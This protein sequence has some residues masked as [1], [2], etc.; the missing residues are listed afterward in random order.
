ME[1]VS[2]EVEREQLLESSIL[3]RVLSCLSSQLQPSFQHQHNN[4]LHN[5]NHHSNSSNIWMLLQQQLLFLTM[6]AR[7]PKVNIKEILGH[8]A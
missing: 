7:A 2:L 3:S 8:K 4:H 5:N 1:R 6:L